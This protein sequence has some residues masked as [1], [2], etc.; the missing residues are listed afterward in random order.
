VILTAF[1]IKS[2]VSL[3]SEEKK[4]MESITPANTQEPSYDN[5]TLKKPSARENENDDGDG[6]SNNDAFAVV[7]TYSSC[8]FSL[9]SY[10][11]RIFHLF[12]YR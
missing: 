5:V 11:I 12:R 8:S 10:F 6:K 7:K 9:K 1:S 4:N 3:M 2:V